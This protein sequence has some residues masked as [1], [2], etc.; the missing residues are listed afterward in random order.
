MSNSGG[1]YRG[2]VATFVP[3]MVLVAA[4][5][6]LRDIHRAA[7]ISLVLGTGVL[8]L[9]WVV[10]M[11]RYARKTQNAGMRIS[12]IVGASL[13]FL[14]CSMCGAIASSGDF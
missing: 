8:Q 12:L 2:L 7:G 5:L 6:V 9:V 14:F 1:V 11:Y 13:V 10:P 3:C 4:G